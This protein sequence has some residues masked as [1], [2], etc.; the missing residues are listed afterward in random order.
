M[1]FIYSTD[2]FQKFK[3]IHIQCSPTHILC[4]RKFG[5]IVNEI[6]H[7]ECQSPRV[8]NVCYNCSQISECFGNSSQAIGFWKSGCNGRVHPI[9][10]FI[11][12]EVLSCHK[13]CPNLS[14]LYSLMLIMW[15]Y[16]GSNQKSKYYIY[17]A[18]RMYETGKQRTIGLNGRGHAHL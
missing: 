1:I 17:T 16:S 2:T 10:D 6:L 12:F 7:S 13:W 15:Q 11:I 14:T 8:Q 9:I 4:F 5:P 18:G 3:S